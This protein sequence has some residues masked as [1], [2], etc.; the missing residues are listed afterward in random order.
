MPPTRPRNVAVR[1]AH[2]DVVEKEERTGAAGENVVDAVIDEIGADPRVRLTAENEG[3]LELGADPVGAGDQE[4]IAARVQPVDTAEVADRL[5]RRSPRNVAWSAC[6]E[7]LDR[8]CRRVDIDAGCRY[9]IG[10][11]LLVWSRWVPSAA[12]RDRL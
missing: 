10:R 12:M 9:A 6:L 8:R 4:P 11:T 1:V 7:P 5:P 3:E 2:R